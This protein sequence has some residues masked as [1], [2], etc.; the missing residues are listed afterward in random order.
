MKKTILLILGLFAGVIS[1]FAQMMPDSTYQVVARWNVG[2]KYHYQVE[3]SKYKIINQTDTSDVE[4]SAEILTFEVVDATDSTYRVRVSSDD[5]QHNDYQRLA[6]HDDLLSQFG[7]IPY[8]FET[9]QYGT[10]KRVIISEEDLKSLY[11]ALDFVVD[12]IA[13]ERGLNDEGKTAIKNMLRAT[14]TQE[15]FVALY[16]QEITP[17][18]WFHGLRLA[19]DA[20]VEYKVDVPS[21]FGDGSTIGMNG[22]FWVDQELTDS[23]SIVLHNVMEAAPED[24][25]KYITTFFGTA[26]NALG[27]DEEALETGEAILQNA[28]IELVDDAYEEIHLNTGWPINYDFVRSIR[29]KAEGQEEEQIQ[30]RKVTIIIENNEEKEQ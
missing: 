2:D 16:Q 10:F 23:Y 27:A 15:R 13:E 9:N 18:I 11:P 25:R 1:A 7:N 12:K 6:L 19:Q 8:E 24:M 4:L 3:E 30:T 29:M 5:F 17:L 26:F 22:N 20:D 14:F 21:F 28:E